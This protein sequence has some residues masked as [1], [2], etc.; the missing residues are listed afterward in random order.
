MPLDPMEAR[1][2]EIEGDVVLEVIIDKKGNITGPIK[3]I[4][5]IP[6]LDQAAIDALRQWRF[7][8][9]GDR[10]NNP[11]RVILDVPVRF[12]LD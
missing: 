2:K 3:T 9:A 4:K 8:P 10:K 11:I 1:V 5:S 12:V 7:L 6:L